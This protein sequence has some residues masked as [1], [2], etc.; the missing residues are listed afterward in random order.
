MNVLRTTLVVALAVLALA[1]PS[2]AAAA[3][4]SYEIEGGTAAERSQI[5]AALNASSFDWSIVATRIVF[6]VARGVDSSAVPGQIWIDANLLD[7]GRFAWGVIQ[8][9]YAHQ[10]DF[11]NLTDADRAALIGPLGGRAWWNPPGATLPHRQLAAERFASTLAW[12]YWSSLDNSLRPSG[13]G[14]ESAAMAP[15]RFRELIERMLGRPASTS[16]LFSVAPRAVRAG[17][18]AR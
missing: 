13:A 16:P 18:Q 11:F 10:V 8:H 15:T 9:E 6:H 14:D 2:T 1:A 5:P 3:G 4:G 17:A 7:S 12:S